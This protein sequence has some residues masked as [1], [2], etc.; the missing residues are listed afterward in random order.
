[1]CAALGAAAAFGCCGFF[2]GFASRRLSFWW[3]TLFSLVAAAAGLLTVAAVLAGLYPAVTVFLAAL[4]LQ[5]R[6]D[7]PQ[8]VGL[9]LAGRRRRPHRHLMTASM[10]RSRSGYSIPV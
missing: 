4:L 5:E 8:L 10:H 3:V 2:A 9:A 1:M 6:P 7:R